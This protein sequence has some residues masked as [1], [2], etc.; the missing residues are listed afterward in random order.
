MIEVTTE[1][2]PDQPGSGLSVDRLRHIHDAIDSLISAFR[3]AEAQAPP[4][5]DL[6]TLKEATSHA[7]GLAIAAVYHS[8]IAWGLSFTK[9]ANY[10]H[11]TFLYICPGLGGAIAPVFSSRV[12][13]QFGIEW[14]FYVASILYGLVLAAVLLQSF[15]PPSRFHVSGSA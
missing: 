4:G 15:R 6:L 14:A 8:F 2:R 13:A 5:F 9:N 3:T 7:Y 1:T 11:V 12:V 10:R